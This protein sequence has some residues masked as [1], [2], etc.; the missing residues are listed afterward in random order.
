V[1]DL[2]GTS[3]GTLIITKSGLDSSTI[4]CQLIAL[5]GIVGRGFDV[6]GDA[7]N[8]IPVRRVVVVVIMPN[9][10]PSPFL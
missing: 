3:R 9:Q 8:D 4:L 1:I 2:L 7:G 6:G 10:K 5:Y